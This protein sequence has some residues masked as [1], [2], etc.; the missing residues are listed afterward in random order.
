MIS[1]P[2]ALFPLA[3]GELPQFEY[4]ADARESVIVNVCVLTESFGVTNEAQFEENES[5]VSGVPVVEG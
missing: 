1:K 2:R 4:G 3:V 5:V